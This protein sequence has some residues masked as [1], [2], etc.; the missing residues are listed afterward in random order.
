MVRNGGTEISHLLQ[1]WLVSCSIGIPLYLGC[2]LFLA[3]EVKIPTPRYSF[4][5]GVHPAAFIE[6]PVSNA[7]IVTLLDASSTSIL[8]LCRLQDKDKYIHLNH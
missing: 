6:R 8:V 7:C 4:V 2:S 1:S 3:L 5:C